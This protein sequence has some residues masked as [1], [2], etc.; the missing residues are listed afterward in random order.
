MITNKTVKLNVMQDMAIT[1]TSTRD[2]MLYFVQYFV[3]LQLKRKL[4]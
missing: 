2:R 4:L 1:L 3:V